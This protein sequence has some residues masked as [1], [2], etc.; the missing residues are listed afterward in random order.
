MRSGLENAVAV[1]W[2]SAVRPGSP[3]SQVGPVV[4]R[5]LTRPRSIH[6]NAGAKPSKRNR[7]VMPTVDTVPLGED[8]AVSTKPF[9]VTSDELTRTPSVCAVIESKTGRNQLA[10][11][12]N[13]TQPIASSAIPMRM[14]TDDSF[15][16]D[17][18]S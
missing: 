1:Y 5:R 12:P 16:F 2:L 9:A 17:A 4:R 8:P 3:Q 10:P 6:N 13:A 15:A 11:S 14:E 18:A 7:M